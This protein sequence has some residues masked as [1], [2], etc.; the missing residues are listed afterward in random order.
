[1]DEIFKQTNLMHANW[2]LNP[3]HETFDFYILTLQSILHLLVDAENTNWHPEDFPLEVVDLYQVLQRNFTNQP[4]INEEEFQH[5][6]IHKLTIKQNIAINVTI[7][8]HIL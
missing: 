6:I 8:I 4:S 7:N 1:M 2:C 3:L 5:L